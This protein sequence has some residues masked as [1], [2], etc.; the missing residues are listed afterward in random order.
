MRIGRTLT[1]ITTA[2]LLLTGSAPALAGG[3]GWMIDF[4][5]AKAKAAAEGKELLIDFTGSDWC[6]WCIRLNKEV[7]SQPEF[8]DQIHDEFVLVELDFPR[9][10]SEMSEETIAQNERLQQEFK[11]RGFPTILLAGADGKPYAKTGYRPGGPEAYLE[12]L[13]ELKSAN[14]ER[15]AAL[16]KADQA[17]GAERARLLDEAL[18][19]LE[20]DA[21]LGMY[22]DRVDQIIAADAQNEAGLKAKYETLKLG[23]ELEETMQN[24]LQKGEFDELIAAADAALPK[25]EGNP[26]LTQVA[27]FFKAIGHLESSRLE[28]GLKILKDA[29]ALEGND[30]VDSQ[31][32]LVIGKVEQAIAAQKAEDAGADD[33]DGG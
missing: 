20:A 27:L 19:A 22:G 7:F 1:A 29:D 17:D 18:G 26:A 33:D 3:A 32:T 10:R 5:A 4:E 23:A 13:V 6:G 25:L 21:L 11:I 31:V 2:A 24:H 9:D 12:H 30:P 15:Q 28:E 8:Q 16:A 14:T